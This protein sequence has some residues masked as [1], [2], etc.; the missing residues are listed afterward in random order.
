MARVVQHTVDGGFSVVGRDCPG[1]G[2]AIMLDP[3]VRILHAADA[4]SG[5]LTKYPALFSAAP[6]PVYAVLPSGGRLLEVGSPCPAAAYESACESAG[7]PI[8]KGRVQLFIEAAGE[9]YYRERH[10]PKL[11]LT[12]A[13]RESVRLMQQS[14]KPRIGVAT[15]SARYGHP[16][17]GA[18][19][20]PWTR[21]L[22][23]KLR[24]IGSVTFFHT[25]AMGVPGT[26]DFQGDLRELV[27][28]IAGQHFMV[29]VDTAAVHIAGA[30]GVPQ[31]ALFGPTD[32]A[33]R[34]SGYP[35]TA[36]IPRFERC[37]RAYCWYR[38]CRPKYCLSLLSPAA[39]VKA[40]GRQ[41]DEE[42]G[43]RGWRAR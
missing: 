25:E 1:I 29:S 33:L 22:L 15:L 26:T 16:F 38:P 43:N 3:L 32:P 41:L 12:A 40:V 23:K 14:T 4:R 19:D 2:D 42:I 11:V 31:L 24:K 30:L 10:I 20:Y 8:R 21:A 18:R 34:V 39:L 37:G 13:E 27:V 36:S 28:T 17:D 35:N 6:Y 9:V 5:L 7:Q